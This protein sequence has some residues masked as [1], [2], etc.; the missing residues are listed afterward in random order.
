MIYDAVEEKYINGM[1]NAYEAF[2]DT[3]YDGF[4]DLA[5]A[6][7]VRRSAERKAKY[8]YK[9]T[10]ANTSSCQAPLPQGVPSSVK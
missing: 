2:I 6:K 7:N 5:Y 3:Y 9:C 4:G 10:V 1:D 8:D